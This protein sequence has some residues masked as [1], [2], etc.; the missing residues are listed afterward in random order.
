MR[1]S[2]EPTPQ[3]RP[4][5]MISTPKYHVFDFLVLARFLGAHRVS[6]ECIQ[7]KGES[8]T[9]G[10]SQGLGENPY[11]HRQIEMPSKPPS[12]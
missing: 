5:T 9:S 6:A 4:R 7:T 8:I 2:E 10:A 3:S 1:L 12:I 11:S